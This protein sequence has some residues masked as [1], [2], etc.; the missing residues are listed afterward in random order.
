MV[1]I[2]PAE[3]ASHE[4]VPTTVHAPFAPKPQ[5]PVAWIDITSLPSSVDHSPMGGA[6]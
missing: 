5:F 1:R 2:P 4:Q 3:E 6:D